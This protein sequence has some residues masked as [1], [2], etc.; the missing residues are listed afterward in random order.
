MNSQRVEFEEFMAR[1]LRIVQNITTTLK[2]LITF[3]CL[4][5]LPSK[6]FKC[7]RFL[8]KDITRKLMSFACRSFIK[9]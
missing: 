3:E 4:R 7:G 9:I 6:V 5:K 8:V 2:F 1:R